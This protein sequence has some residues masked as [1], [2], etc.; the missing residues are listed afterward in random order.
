MAGVPE[1]TGVD[2]TYDDYTSILSKWD[3][4]YFVDDVTEI[5]AATAK[6]LHDTLR[7]TISA[8]PVGAI[9]DEWIATNQQGTVRWPLR[10]L[11]SAKKS[12]SKYKPP[13]PPDYR[14]V[15]KCNGDPATGMIISDY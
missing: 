4:E 14:S 6:G 3:G 11:Y 12:N 13:E 1:G 2:L 8:G 10:L 9:L 15:C 7:P 5:D